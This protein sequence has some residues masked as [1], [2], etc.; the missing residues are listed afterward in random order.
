ME[1]WQFIQSPNGEWYWLCSEVL[2]HRTRTSTATFQTES[3]CIADARSNGYLRGTQS[4]S[5]AKR[6]T[7][8]RQSRFG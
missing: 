7:G 1:R 6:M 5:R 2:S 8:S 4:G 3:Q